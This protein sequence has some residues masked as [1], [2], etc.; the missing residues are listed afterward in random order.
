MMLKSSLVLVD[1]GHSRDDND[2]RERGSAFELVDV[3]V[4]VPYG[5]ASE[6][7]VHI[8]R[9]LPIYCGVDHEFS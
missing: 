9:R 1:S 4:G 7:V 6:H 3:G 5:V 2:T 8:V